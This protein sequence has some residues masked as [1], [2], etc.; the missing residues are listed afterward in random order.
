MTDVEPLD[1]LIVDR[2]DDKIVD[3][4]GDKPIYVSLPGRYSLGNSKDARGDPRLFA[5]R[6]V[7]ISAHEIAVAAP[8]T[9]KVGVRVTANIEQ[10]GRLR[11]AISRVFE[12]GFAM[13]IEASDQEREMLAS[14]I[15]WI[16]KNKDFE[17]SDNRTHARFIPKRPL[18]LLTLADGSVV[19]CFVVDISVS[20]AAVSADIVPKMGTVLAV[21]KVVGRVVRYIAGGFAVQFIEAQDRQEVEALVIRR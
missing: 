17:I 21:G 19:P 15:D 11:G 9:A 12:L 13:N 4:R 2:R 16:E 18:S 5:C 10:L 1:L 8:V 20:G 3:R 14:K 6:A 7:S